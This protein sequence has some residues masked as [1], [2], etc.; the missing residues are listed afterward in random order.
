MKLRTVL[1]SVPDPRGKQGQD[2]FLWS[3]LS[4]IVVSMLCGRRGCLAAFRLGRSLNKRQRKALGFTKGTTP[5]HATLTETL[6]AIDGRTL[7]QTL[8]AACFVAGEDARHVMIDGKTMRAT[9]D[10][11]GRATHVLSAF[12]ASLQSIVGNEASRGKGMEIPDALKLLDQLDLKD[13][14]V[15]GDAMFCQKSITAK[16]AGKG[17]GYVFPVKDNQKNLRE[18]IETAFTEPVFS[19]QHF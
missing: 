16:I 17:G 10:G 18:N 6:R 15:S 5:C 19:P 12:C 1:Q 2:Y 7:A 8:G 13:K 9:K 3:I 11:E 14:I 4:L